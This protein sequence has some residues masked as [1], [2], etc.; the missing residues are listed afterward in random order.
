MLGTVLSALY[1]PLPASFSRAE[2]GVAIL[3]LRVCVCIHLRPCG[4]RVA[5]FLELCW[6]LLLPKGPL[7]ASVQPCGGLVAVSRH[8]KGQIRR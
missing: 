3:T 7:R 1:Q 6:S 4:S 8:R 5:G 2:V